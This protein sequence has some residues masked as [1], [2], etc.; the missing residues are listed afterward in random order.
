MLQ[1]YKHIISQ[2]HQNKVLDNYG[3]MTALQL[4]SALIGFVLYPIVIRR[5]GIE[6]YGWYVFIFT[7]VQYF[8]I[9]IEFGFD[10]PA[11]KAVSFHRDNKEQLSK[12]VS[13]MACVKGLLFMVM[14]AVAILVVEYVEVLS[15]HRLLF[16]VLFAQNAV[17]ILFPQWYFQGMK[18]MKIP[19]VINLL[20]RIA[21]IPLVIGLITA[22][23]EVVV[24]AAIVTGTM[25]LGAVA[26]MVYMLGQ[27]IRFCTVS[28]ADILE[29]V[30]AGWPFFLTDLAGSL[31]E[32]VLTNII[33]VF[34]GM[35]EVA[36]YDL[37]SKVVQIP[38]MFTQ[39][40][41]KALFP[42]VVT[43]AT[44]ELVNKILRYERWIGLGMMVFVVALGYWI[45]LFMGGKEMLDA[46]PAAV[47]LSASIYTW[48]VVGAYLQFVF[49]STN[50]YSFVTW[51]QVV[52]LLTCLLIAGIGLWLCP[53]VLVVVSAIVVSGF[54]EIMFCR[55]MCKK[56]QLL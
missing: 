38:R 41:N 23:G 15:T 29:Y 52:A 19:T 44:R 27:G 32:R 22:G 7:I 26:A 20:C 13:V 55:M 24:Y 28:K 3:Y 42:E 40:I 56:K 31:K 54:A 14:A 6:Q 43:K 46:Y 12:I 50:H 8:Q 2:L 39:S 9:V 16:W 51:N 30:R 5:V 35:R 49:I 18:Q 10:F 37:A 4:L 17:N 33:G 25:M 47:I 34:L 53:S 45:V 48:L 1:K 21:Q 36:I 11:I